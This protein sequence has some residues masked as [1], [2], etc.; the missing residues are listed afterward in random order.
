LAIPLPGHTAGS[1]AFLLEQ[2]RLF[3]GDSLA[4]DFSADDLT[5]HRHVC[6]YSWPERLASPRR[7]LDHRFEW[8]LAG[9]GGST[10]RPAAEMNRRLGALLA[11]LD[12]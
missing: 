2:R 4:W 3:T 6:W 5:A 11:R 8:V 9:H 12:P 1:V 10:D 7:L